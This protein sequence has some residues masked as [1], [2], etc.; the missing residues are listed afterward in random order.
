MEIVD[1]APGLGLVQNAAGGFNSLIG[2]AA[3]LAVAGIGMVLLL[4]GQGG[5]DDDDSSP[6]GGLM[7]PIA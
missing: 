7:Q 5:N 3:A 4:P 2:L 1:L 6:G